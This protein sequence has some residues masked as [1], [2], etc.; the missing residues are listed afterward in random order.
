MVA[1]RWL[2]KR[3]GKGCWYVLIY[4][5]YQRIVYIPRLPRLD[6]KASGAGR[7][8]EAK[9][10]K[11]FELAQAVAVKGETSWPEFDRAKSLHRLGL[12]PEQRASLKHQFQV[13]AAGGG[14]ITRDSG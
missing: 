2:I 9:F 12:T 3:L 1:C 10:H 4:S 13:P 14:F 8:P 11:L 6:V 7:T 5:Q